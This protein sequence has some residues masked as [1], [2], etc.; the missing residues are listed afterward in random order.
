MKLPNNYGSISKL[1]GNRRRPYIVRKSLGTTQYIIGYYSTHE[2]ALQALADYNRQHNQEIPTTAVTLAT[3]YKEWLPRHSENLSKSSICGYENS[4]RYLYPIAGIPLSKLNYSDFQSIVDNMQ[5]LSYASKKKVRSLI[6][7]LCKHAIKSDYLQ[8]NWGEYITIGKN[9]PIRPHKPFTRQQ[10]NRLWKLNTSE[11]D[12]LL[13]LLYSGMRCGELLNLR[14][15]DINLK[16]KTMTINKSK[17]RAGIRIIPIHS[18][19]FDI[20]KRRYDS[21]TDFLFKYTY[22][23]FAKTCKALTRNKH[24]THDARHTVASLL[25]SAGAN[26]NA[27]RA[28]L[29]HK[30]GDITIKVYTHK[31]LRDLR[32]AIEMLK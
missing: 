32:K 21:T 6:N 16:T 26:P 24:T 5:G 17:T 11:S 19:I 3:I 23:Q 9:K 2:D 31:T 7:H 4:Y 1:S 14:K 30:N 10:I 22:N 27:V 20:I 25:D 13:V 18:R 12:G 29:G 8:R 15:R 28:I